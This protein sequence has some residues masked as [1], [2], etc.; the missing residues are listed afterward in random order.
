M[1]TT[2]PNLYALSAECERVCDLLERADELDA[3]EREAMAAYAEGLRTEAATKVDQYVAAL[4]RLDTLAE[5]RAAEAKAVKAEADRTAARA[6]SLREF[7]LTALERLGMD[8]VSGQRW[9][10]ARQPSYAVDVMV[11]TDRIPQCWLREKPA[12]YE[13]DRAKMLKALKAG[14]TIDGVAL[15]TNWHLRVK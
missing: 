2:E 10:I 9:T 11:E 5:A 4:R 14:E 8:A 7:L 12:T 3:D 1:T 13:P 6:D 15:Q